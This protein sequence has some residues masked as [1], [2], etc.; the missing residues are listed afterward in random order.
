MLNMHSLSSWAEVC[1]GPK[2]M[3]CA[4]PWLHVT[5]S[6]VYHWIVTTLR[7]PR[8]PHL[9]SLYV[10]IQ[11]PILPRRYQTDFSV[12]NRPATLLLLLHYES[13][14]ICHIGTLQRLWYTRTLYTVLRKSSPVFL[15]AQKLLCKESIYYDTSSSSFTGFL[16][17]TCG[18]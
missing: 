5:V 11:P 1:R 8:H 4:I 10:Y 3:G 15:L 7:L 9:I 2:Y 14:I 17:S 16:Q 12:T 18:F 13:A 6:V